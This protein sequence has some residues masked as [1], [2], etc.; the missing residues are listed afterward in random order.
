MPPKQACTSSD[1][2]PPSLRVQGNQILSG[3]SLSEYKSTLKMIEGAI[4]ATDLALYMK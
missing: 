4:L 3:L 1:V 2:T